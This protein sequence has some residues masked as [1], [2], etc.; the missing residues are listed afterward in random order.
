MG[1]CISCSWGLSARQPY[2][3]PYLQSLYR[4]HAVPSERRR[5]YSLVNKRK[6]DLGHLLMLLANACCPYS[7]TPLQTTHPT[8]TCKFCC[9]LTACRH[10][11]AVSPGELP[12]PQVQQCGAMR[13]EWPGRPTQKPVSK[14]LFRTS[15][16]PV[17]QQA[18]QHVA[19]RTQLPPRR[20]AHP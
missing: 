15:S 14:L 4:G 1:V 5:A 19:R 8:I 13:G 2:L 6:A 17:L 9:R 20:R 16:Q 10:S 11:P 3:Q 12:L 18:P 7:I